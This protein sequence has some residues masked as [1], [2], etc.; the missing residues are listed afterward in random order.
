MQRM[1][2]KRKPVYIKT[3]IEDDYNIGD[4]LG[5]YVFAGSSHPF[6]A[7]WSTLVLFSD[8]SG[9]YSTVKLAVH[10][11]TG[12]KRAVKI[13][14]KENAGAK[15]IKMVQTEVEIML[16]CE[17]PNMVKYVL[18]VFLVLGSHSFAVQII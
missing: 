10:K 15:G 7:L 2:A 14:N 1:Q 9:N 17:H 11:K 18:V 4:V 16:D 3:P 12:Q 8:T 13:I 6:N 5:T